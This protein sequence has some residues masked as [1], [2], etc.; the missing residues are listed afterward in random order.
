MYIYTPIYIY[1]GFYLKKKKKAV[2]LLDLLG[3]TGC[4]QQML[5]KTPSEKFCLAL[6]LGSVLGP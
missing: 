5:L 1:D 2:L 3:K 4:S 6:T